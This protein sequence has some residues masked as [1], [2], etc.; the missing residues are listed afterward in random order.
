MT[1]IFDKLWPMTFV[2]HAFTD[3]V[4]GRPVNYYRTSGSGRIVMA[5]TRWSFF[6]VPTI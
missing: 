6:R 3:V 1:K 2:R 4:S 5:E